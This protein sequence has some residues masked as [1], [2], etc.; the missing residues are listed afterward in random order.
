LFGVLLDHPRGYPLA[1][2][3]SVDQFAI[4]TARFP[5]RSISLAAAVSDEHPSMGEITEDPKTWPPPNYVDPVNQ[6]SLI[7]GCV[8]TSLIIMD[9][10]W[11]GRL[12]G[13]KVVKSALGL[14]D[15]LMSAAA[16]C[17]RILEPPQ[18]L[19]LT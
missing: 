2:R 3:L 7:L 16:V 12:V 1:L 6:T 9:V 13:R 4:S 18:R 17:R 11:V 14:D 8:I 19:Q 15:W 10:F 5:R